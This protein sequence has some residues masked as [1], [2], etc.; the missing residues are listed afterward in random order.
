VIRAVISREGIP[1]D[2]RVVNT[3]DIDV[4]LIQAALESVRQWRY[5]P[6]ELNG[7]PVA[8]VTTIFVD[9]KLYP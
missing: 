7:V 2:L 5:Q 8:N 6:A 3:E 4:R 9:F 1:T